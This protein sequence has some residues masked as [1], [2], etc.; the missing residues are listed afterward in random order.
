MLNIYERA[1]NNF[2]Y[3]Y[4]NNIKIFKSTGEFYKIRKEII[5]EKKLN[6]FQNK[7]KIDLKIKKMKIDKY[8]RKFFKFR[9]FPRKIISSSPF[10]NIFTKEKSLEIKKNNKIIDENENNMLKY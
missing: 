9:Y 4:K 2:L 1:I 3:D 6:L 5:N 8:N 7:K 10:N